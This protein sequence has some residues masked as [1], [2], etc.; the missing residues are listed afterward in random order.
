MSITTSKQLI[1]K[2]FISLFS[3]ISVNANCESLTSMKCKESNDG[4]IL[5][6]ILEKLD[7]T[8]IFLPKIPQ[9][10]IEELKNQQLIVYELQRRGMDDKLYK[11]AFN[12]MIDM[13]YYRQWDY[14][15]N[16]NKLKREINE[17]IILETNNKKIEELFKHAYYEKYKGNVNAIKLDIAIETNAKYSNF[18]YEFFSKNSYDS[19]V[20]KEEDYKKFGLALNGLVGIR[21]SFDTYMHCKLARII[22]KK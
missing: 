10:N 8:L 13:K 16:M 1:I 19:T 2:F 17:L 14:I 9:E 7:G 6:P 11:Q 20:F 3:L 21:Q 12:S 18:D 5:Q 15:N 4:M 22:E